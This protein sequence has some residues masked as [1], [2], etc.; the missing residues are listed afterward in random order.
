M[1][2]AYRIEGMIARG[3]D[4]HEG[5]VTIAKKKYESL[6]DALAAIGGWVDRDE[7]LNVVCFSIY[8]DVTGISWTVVPHFPDIR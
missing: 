5:D 1:H 2:L 3:K 7:F 4:D 8:N 6:Q